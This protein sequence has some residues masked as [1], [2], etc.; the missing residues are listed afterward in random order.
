MN[1]NRGFR[2]TAFG[3][4]VEIHKT[5]YTKLECLLKKLYIY[6]YIYI[7]IFIFKIETTIGL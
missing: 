6:I 1:N 7:Y 5:N 2:I 3:T 4:A